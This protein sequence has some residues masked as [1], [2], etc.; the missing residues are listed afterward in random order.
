MAKDGKQLEG[1]VRYIE[2]QLLP[3][4]FKVEPNVR[5]YDEDGDQTGEFDVQITGKLGAGSIRWLIECRDR[6]SSGP[7]PG[8]WIE[9]L[10]ARRDRFN[11]DKVTAVS[12][13]GFAKPVGRWPPQ[14]L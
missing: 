12:T 11:F 4:G 14:A 13:T 3:M 1:L 6:P 2:E 7:Q 10:V 8:A 9:Q 5:V